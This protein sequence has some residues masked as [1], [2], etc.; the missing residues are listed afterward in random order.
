MAQDEVNA[1]VVRAKQ[2]DLLDDEDN[3]RMRMNGG[4]DEGVGMEF[5]DRDGTVRLAIG[6]NREGTAVVDAKDD[7][8]QTRARIGVEAS[9]WPALFSLRNGANNIV[10]QI[11]MHD[12]ESPSVTLTDGMG[13][14]L[15]QIA[16]FDGNEGSIRVNGAEIG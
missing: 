13:T 5:Y 3:L 15:V 16:V 1:D 9:G 7:T 10:A 14:T 8:G 6:V 2:F 4:A 12:D 11:A